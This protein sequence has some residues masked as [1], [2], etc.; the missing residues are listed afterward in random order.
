MFDQVSSIYQSRISIYTVA[1]SY[2]HSLNH[3]VS[4][5]KELLKSSSSTKGMQD[6]SN[7]GYYNIFSKDIRTKN[8][9]E[10]KL[11]SNNDNPF[12]YLYLSIVNIF[13]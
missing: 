9:K 10:N 8:D 11:Q 5:T 7:I 13:F 12:T 6:R 4:N 3:L 1:L 2:T